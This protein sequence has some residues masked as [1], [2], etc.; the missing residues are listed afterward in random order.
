[1]KY[2]YLWKNSR[3]FVVLLRKPVVGYTIEKLP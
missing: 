3:I 2:I 1:M